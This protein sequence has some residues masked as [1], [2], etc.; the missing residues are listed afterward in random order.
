MEKKEEPQGMRAVLSRKSSFEMAHRLRSAMTEE[1]NSTVHGHSY[2]W[3]LSLMGL[4]SEKTG[5]L[6][7]Y[8]VLKTIM[9]S[10]NSFLD[11]ACWIPACYE[12]Y[13][14]SEKKL[15]ISVFEPTAEMICAVI[16]NHIV[17]TLRE[18]PECTE[19]L[20]NIHVV[21]VCLRETEDTSVI[22]GLPVNAV[23]N[24][25]PMLTELVQMR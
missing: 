6:A 24:G 14:K 11:H 19:F 9:E 22:I 16:C 18:L 15:L 13:Y 20:G 4:V 17:M 5:M 12:E 10:I 3:E 25:I 21:S 7:D 2:H 8:K 23:V 1:C